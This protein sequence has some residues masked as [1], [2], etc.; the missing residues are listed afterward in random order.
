MDID[1]LPREPKR[2]NMVIVNDRE[3]PR[4]YFLMASAGA[5]VLFGGAFGGIVWANWSSSQE[6]S[7]SDEAVSDLI[8][9]ARQQGWTYKTRDA[10]GV[11]R[12]E[13]IAPFPNVS[14][15]LSA[16]DDM[17]G[18]YRG[19]SIRCFEYRDEK[20]VRSA[21]STRSR[22]KMTY[23]SVFSVATPAT[24]PRTVVREPGDLDG[25]FADDKLEKFLRTDPRAEGVPLRFDKGELITW[26]EGRLRSEDVPPKLNYLCDV[27]E[28]TPTSVWE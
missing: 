4:R 27:L 7:R 6:D 12:Y 28:H 15:G 5:F 20:S 9:L 22:T 3:I 8:A 1:D 25:D 18:R 16:W 2:R 24:I 13:G 10:G 19:R 11:D 14:S 23:Y 21:G 26:Y 17:E